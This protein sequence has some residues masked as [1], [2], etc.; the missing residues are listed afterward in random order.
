VKSGSAQSLLSSDP[1]MTILQMPSRYE[2]PFACPDVWPTASSADVTSPPSG[3]F[4]LV[5]QVN[6]R[7]AFR[8]EPVDVS[9]FVFKSTLAKN[10]SMRILPCGFRDLTF[11]KAQ[12]QGRDVA[13]RQ[14]VREVSSG[15]NGRPFENSHRNV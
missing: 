13:T 2:V 11:G 3:G 14:M 5:R 10:V 4:R 1:E 8:P 12:F 6:G 7:E 15:E 9:S